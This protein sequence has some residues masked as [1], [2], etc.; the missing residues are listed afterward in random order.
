MTSVPLTVTV[1]EI[2]R[3]IRDAGTTYTV[4]STAS[5]DYL[6]LYIRVG[7][8][9]SGQRLFRVGICQKT[10]RVVLQELSTRHGRTEDS[11]PDA[12]YYV[13]PQTGDRLSDDVLIA[14]YNP[15]RL[16]GHAC[17]VREWA[18]QNLLAVAREKARKD[19]S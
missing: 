17:S 11:P 16:S 10:S 4:E 12:D 9:G 8:V 13:C 2:N 3:A 5:Q 15:M 7:T 19:A 1:E 14:R 18:V 6:S